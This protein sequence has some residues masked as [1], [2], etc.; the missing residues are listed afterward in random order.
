MKNTRKGFTLVELLAVIVIL[1]IIMIIA[2]PAVLSTMEQARQKTFSEYVTKVHNA[3]NNFYLKNISFDTDAVGKTVSIANGT[4]YVYTLAQIGMTSTGD[5]QGAAAVCVKDTD[6]KVLVRL[7]DKNYHNKSV[8]NSFGWWNFSDAGEV[9]V[10][11]GLATGAA[12][13]FDDV[14]SVSSTALEAALGQKKTSALTDN[15]AG[16]ATA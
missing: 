15:K 11:T 12:T 2:I 9:D 5:Y 8:A 14:D 3:A 4:C 16:K 6:I 7:T 1:A 10:K 13:N